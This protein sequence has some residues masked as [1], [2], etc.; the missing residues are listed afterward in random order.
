VR[1]RWV[2]GK[3]AISYVESLD[4]VSNIWMIPVATGV[5][6]QLTS[7]TSGRI[8][9]FDWSRDGTLVYSQ[10][11]NTNDV[12]LMREPGKPAGR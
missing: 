6:Q 10:G 2:P 7:F 3:N 11:M 5:P 1:L 8:Y 4:G 12:V 9:S